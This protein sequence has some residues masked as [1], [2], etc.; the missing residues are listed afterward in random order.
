VLGLP[1]PLVGQ[2]EVDLADVP[3]LIVLLSDLAVAD[4]V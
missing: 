2:R 3:A 4:Q 1:P